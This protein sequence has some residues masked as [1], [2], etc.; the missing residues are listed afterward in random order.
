[1]KKIPKC[2][3]DKETKGTCEFSDEPLYNLD[4][5]KSFYPKLYR[6]ILMNMNID[7]PETIDFVNEFYFYILKKGTTIVH[8]TTIEATKINNKYYYKN[9]I[10]WWK[11]Y[12]PG[13]K[14]YKGGWFTYKTSFG[15]PHFNTELF[16][17]VERDIPLIYIPKF[18]RNDFIKTCGINSSN[19]QED[20]SDF[21][22]C[23]YY[24]E[25]KKEINRLIK[26]EKLDQI[27]KLNTDEYLTYDNLYS[28]LRW[29]SSHLIPGV[30]NWKKKGYKIITH[31][32]GE[33]ADDLGLRIANLGFFGYI[34]CDECEIYLTHKI[35]KE[36][37]L[38]PYKYEFSIYHS[39][40]DPLW[41]F[42]LRTIIDNQSEN[43]LKI[44]STTTRKTGK[45]DF[46]EVPNDIVQ[47]AKLNYQI[48]NLIK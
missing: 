4:E 20:T 39:F 23:K 13:Q 19:P 37:L 16:Y 30:K 12:Y 46:I 15:G 29:E 1:M 24:K 40:D 26:E 22:D 48:E 35:M 34:S 33:Y 5:L 25:I 47:D 11:D 14:D 43:K 3:P 17:R 31:S 6:E 36:S 10:N 21:Y 9:S 32:R 18:Y 45:Y 41:K 8:T 28:L 38:H 42:I 7:D 44:T 27:I 2:S